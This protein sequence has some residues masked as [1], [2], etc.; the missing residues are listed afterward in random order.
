[1]G[2]V[3]FL[4]A[5]VALG[6]FMYRVRTK[7]LRA[8]QHLLICPHCQTKGRINR[9]LDTAKG[10]I[11]GGKA[12]GAILTGGVSLLFTGLSRKSVVTRNHCGA[13][14]TTWRS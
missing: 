5:V 11:S 13:C 7:A 10:P 9:S 2:V 14:N 3:L 1:M 6:L 12:T 4:L 8:N